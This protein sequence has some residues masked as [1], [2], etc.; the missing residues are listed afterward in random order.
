MSQQPVPV[1]VLESGQ[2]VS[3]RV[4]NVLQIMVEDVLMKPHNKLHKIKLVL[5]EFY[6]EFR[7]MSHLKNKEE[8]EDQKNLNIT[9]LLPGSQQVLPSLQRWC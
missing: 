4:Q 5:C 7:E 6:G 2:Q 8:R 3:P 9:L 1:L